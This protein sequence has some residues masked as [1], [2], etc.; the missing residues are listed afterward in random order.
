MDN[1]KN[2]RLRSKNTWIFFTRHRA[3]AQY[4]ANTTEL[5]D[6]RFRSRAM[7]ERTWLL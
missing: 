7:A 1:T 4:G 6:F 5:L 2:I 3:E